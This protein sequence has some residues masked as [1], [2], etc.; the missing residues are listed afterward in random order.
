MTPSG[1]RSA[2]WMSASSAGRRRLDLVTGAAQGGLERPQDLRLVV[3]DEDPGTA[4]CEGTERMNEAP[5]SGLG[6]AS[7]VAPFA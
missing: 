7:S 6:S 5:P 3:D 1:G 4:H 2:A